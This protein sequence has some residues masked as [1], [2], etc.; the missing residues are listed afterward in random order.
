MGERAGVVSERAGVVGEHSEV[1]ND[2]RSLRREIEGVGIF[3]THG[4]ADGV[5]SAIAAR[6]VGISAEVNPL[7]RWLLLQ[8]VGFAVGVML[9]IVGAMAVAYPRLAQWANIPRW[10]AP[11]L[12]GFGLLVA[13]GNVAVVVLA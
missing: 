7:V 8:G 3:L 1:G 11:V 6:S 10:F 13:I 9:L 5:T 4:I 12:I 2:S